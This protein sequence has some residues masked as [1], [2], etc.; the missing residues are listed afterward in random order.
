MGLI[1]SQ[2]DD[3]KPLFRNWVKIAKKQG[4]D[5]IED[6]VDEIRLSASEEWILIEGIESV[7]LLNFESK[8]GQ[9]L[10]ASLQV[11]KGELKGLKIVP[12]KG[13][14]GFDLEIAEDLTVFWEWS[15]GS[16]SRKKHSTGIQSFQEKF[17]LENMKPAKLGETSM[18][19]NSGNGIKK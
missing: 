14:L 4:L 10:W 8:A 13:K 15:E 19:K 1:N 17:S 2:D 6:I 3:K 11:F 7:A 9:D 5:P 18:T 12:A 16:L